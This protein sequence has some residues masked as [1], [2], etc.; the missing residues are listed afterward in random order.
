MNNLNNKIFL[1]NKNTHKMESN[2]Y[3]FRDV[4][5]FGVVVYDDNNV[6]Y[7]IVE[8]TTCQNENQHDKIERNNLVEIIMLRS[9]SKVKNIIQAKSTY[10]YDNLKDKNAGIK[11]G[12]FQPNIYHKCPWVIK[13]YSILVFNRMKMYKGNLFSLVNKN[14]INFLRKNFLS[15][16]KQLLIAVNSLHKIGLLHGDIKSSNI[17]YNFNE[18]EGEQIVLIDLGG[19]KPVHTDEYFKTCT[20]TTR[21]PEDLYYDTQTNPNTVYNS[22]GFKSD[23]WSL[24]IVFCELILG[25]NPITILYNEFK[26]T[27][28]FEELIEIKLSNEF[29]KVEYL[30]IE[31]LIINKIK[32][33]N[34]DR[35]LGEKL[36]GYAKVIKRM[37][38]INP[39]YRVDSI[40]EVYEE[41]TGEIIES[42]Q[43]VYNYVYPN[44]NHDE[45]LDFRIL[46]YEKVI[47]L[48][49]KIT[50]GLFHALPFLVDLLDRFFSK[51]NLVERNDS[52]THIELE[53]IGVS[54]IYL[55]LI[56]FEPEL[57]TF[58]EI[59]NKIKFKYLTFELLKDYILQ[60]IVFMDYDM[61]R[62]YLDINKN[63]DI[64]KIVMNTLNRKIV[65][66][67]P[68]YYSL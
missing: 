1:I 47:E 29:K 7:K 27:S 14:N 53:L 21:C 26:Q 37:L 24:G 4:G 31:K 63:L 66:L 22:S 51:F 38:V 67:G 18:P 56:W 50:N 62:P 45:F 64:K 34:I 28:S 40:C 23:I 3:F 13:D 44:I 5:S 41:L 59:D 55:T 12:V 60:V 2:I 49:C 16:A 58:N 43:I 52:I 25:Y 8:I 46:Y 17:L 11:I 35:T 6:L 39:E 57:F 10:Y 15:I 42:K 20:L 65:G 32:S 30:D 9:L 33:E 68:E 61:F 54:M 48:F 19:V 36:I